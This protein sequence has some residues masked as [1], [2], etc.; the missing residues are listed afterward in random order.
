MGPGCRDFAD[1]KQNKFNESLVNLLAHGEKLV[2]LTTN[3]FFLGAAEKASSST[4]YF[5][6]MSFLALPKKRDQIPIMV[7]VSF[8]TKT[9]Q[10]LYRD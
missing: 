8:F 5:F 3:P 2:F 7:F 10:N 1:F 6:Y 4:F 9:L